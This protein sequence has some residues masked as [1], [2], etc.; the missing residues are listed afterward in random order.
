MNSRLVTACLLAAGC[1]GVCK[2]VE[3]S[4]ECRAMELRMEGREPR[5]FELGECGAA[6]VYCSKGGGAFG[7]SFALQC[8]GCG[9]APAGQCVRVYSDSECADYLYRIN[10]GIFPSHIGSFNGSFAVAKLVPDGEK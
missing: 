7:R 10:F 6:D 2:I 4:R 1:V 3:V 5:R 9:G 8:Y